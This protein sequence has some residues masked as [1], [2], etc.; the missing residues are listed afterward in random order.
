[1]NNE[2]LANKEMKNKIRSA[3]QYVK[4]LSTTITKD[5]IIDLPRLILI[6]NHYF[7]ILSFYCFKIIFIFLFSD[8]YSLYLSLFLSH[9][10]PPADF[11]GVYTCRR[12]KSK[13][14]KYDQLQTR[15]GDEPMTNFVTCFDCKYK[16]R[17]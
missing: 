2:E 14:T 9:P 5:D 11:E 7:I 17:D 3:K 15:G 13:R 6:I 4:E 12:C 10:L 1:M 8:F 16:F